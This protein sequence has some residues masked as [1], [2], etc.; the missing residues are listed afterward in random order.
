[1]QSDLSNRN[2]ELNSSSQQGEKSVQHVYEMHVSVECQTVISIRLSLGHHEQQQQQAFTRFPYKTLQPYDKLVSPHNVRFTFTHKYIDVDMYYI[3]ILSVP[4][5]K[6]NKEQIEFF[7]CSSMLH[8]FMVFMECY[9][10][11]FFKCYEGTQ[12]SSLDK[13]TL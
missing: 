12:S 10:K 6:S 1:M 13:S 4:M 5:G 7:R 9:S 11:L 8:I 3:Q 2:D